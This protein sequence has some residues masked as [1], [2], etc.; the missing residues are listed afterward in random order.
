MTLF[1]DWS[2]VVISFVGLERVWTQ[3]FHEEGVYVGHFWAIRG[4]N[5]YEA[6]RSLL[7]I[8]CPTPAMNDVIPRLAAFYRGAPP[9]DVAQ[10][11]REQRYVTPKG[12]HS[13]AVDK[14]L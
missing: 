7:I 10:G 12:M 11:M 3:A 2:L 6:A 13:W 8:G 14:A 5:S 4:L 9:L 1:P